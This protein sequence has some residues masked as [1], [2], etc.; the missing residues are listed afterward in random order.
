MIIPITINQIPKIDKWVP[1]PQDIIF[2]NAKN[3]IIAP[4]A[5][6]LKLN[7]DTLDYFIIRPK[8]CYNSQDLRDHVCMVLNYFEKYFDPDKELLICMA[9]MKYTMDTFQEYNKG[10]FMHDI[11]LYILSGSLQQKVIQLAEYNYELNLTYKNISPALQYDNKH[12]KILLEMSI[13]MDFVIPLI[14]HFAQTRR[15]GKIDE[16]ILDVFDIILNMFGVDIFAKL[17]ET[18]I[19]NVGK[20]E[21][22]NAPLWAKQDIRGKDVVTHSSDSVNNIILNIMPKYAFDRN[23]VALNYTSIQKNT[24]C[25]VTEIGYE[26]GFVPLSSSKR[27]G[28]DNTSDLDKYE[29]SLLKSNEAVFLQMDINCKMTIKSIEAQFGPFNPDEIE[30]YRKSLKNKEGNIMNSFQKQIIYNL[31]YKYFGD[32]VSI[33]SINGA[34]DYIILMLAAKKILQN[35]YMIIMP[36]IISGKV[37]NLV[38]RKTINKK[39]EL[40]LKASPYYPMIVAKYKSERII[41]QILSSIATILSSNFRIIDYNNPN[42]NGKM[43]DTIPDIVMEEMLATV[44]LY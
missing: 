22:K 24:N 6:Y 44:L 13:L 29:V 18:S 32:T 5:N 43:I 3:V 39:E 25:Q 26:F 40:K 2:T 19:T 31:F 34:R 23:I 9:R 10:N 15:V 8:K 14:T 30:F 1:D 20:S 4:I 41:Q 28:E 33:N 42:I 37:E 27:D 11:S 12:A 17:Y 36:Y 16:F 21:Y 7:S 38:T 35:N